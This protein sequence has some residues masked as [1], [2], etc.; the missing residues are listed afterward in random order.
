MENKIRFLF[1]LLGL[2]CGLM[3]LLSGAGTPEEVLRTA[4]KD[5]RLASFKEAVT[6]ST[7]ASS[8]Y[9][10]DKAELKFDRGELTQDDVKVGLRIYPKGYSEHATTS[11]F[12]KAL[13]KNDRI[14]QSEAISKVL[15]SR[16]ELLARVAL[17]R[18]KKQIAGELVQVSRKASRALSFAAKKDRSEL[19]SF[20][21][22]KS[23]LDKIDVKIADIDRDYR[24]LQ[25]ELKDLELGPAESFE[26][27]DLADMDDI[28]KRIEAT[29]DVPVSGTLSAQAAELDLVKTRA[30]IDYDRAKD[31]KWL[32]HIEVSMK[33]DKHEKVYGIEVSFNLP[34]A[35]APDLSRIDKQ[36]RE[37]REKA[38]VIETAQVSGR[39]FKNALVELR[40]LLDVHRSLRESQMRMNPEQMRKA[41]QAIAAQDPLLAVELQRGWYE[42]REQVLDLEFRIRTLFI[43][44][45]HE[46]STLASAP[47]ANYLSK[48]LKRIM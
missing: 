17:L 10:I 31:D 33:E 6:I 13:E 5:S 34:F 43:I 15:S 21:K 35:S 46:S 3:P 22:T 2:G 27:G 41:S 7:E 42:S 32:D 14:A 40:M 18:E 23:D 47:E 26:L 9:P 25:V 38:K 48:S 30:G 29:A 45:L 44:F 37:L 8:Y 1:W 12:Q 16:Y 20:L 11:R 19:K 4:W 28:R 36:T 24:N 39:E